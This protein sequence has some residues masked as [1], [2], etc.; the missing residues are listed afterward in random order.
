M[1]LTTG[2]FAGNVEMRI[3]ALKDSDKWP[4]LDETIGYYQ[5]T[6]SITGDGIKMAKEVGA[7]LIWKMENIQL[8]PLG[9][10]T[11]GSLSGKHRS[12]LSC[13]LHLRQRRRRTFYHGDDDMTLSLFDKPI[14]SCI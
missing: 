2:G 11:T 10:P 1:V 12:W 5:Y 4:A 9:D 13:E 3:E 7:N 14:T 6:S 8:L